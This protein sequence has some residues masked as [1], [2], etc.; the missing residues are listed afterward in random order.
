MFDIY[1]CR[2]S[3]KPNSTARPDSETEQEL[4]QVVLKEGTSMDA[5]VFILSINNPL[6]WNYAYVPSLGRYYWIISAR[7]TH[8]QLVEISCATDILATFKTYIGSSRSYVL[9]SSYTF[10]GGIIDTMFPTTAACTTATEI[11]L[12]P[13]IHTVGS[14]NISITEGCFII[15]Y[16]TK[17]IPNSDHMYGSVIYSAIEQDDLNDLVQELLDDS[18]LEDNGFELN[19]ASLAL[20]KSIVDPLSYIKS[21]IWVPVLYSAISGS[22]LS[23]LNIW[24][25]SIGVNHKI[26]RNDPPYIQYS[27]GS[28]ALTK[29]PQTL[30]KGLWTNLS[31]Y[32]RINL[33]YPP[34][35]NIEL[36]TTLTCNVNSITGYILIDLVTGMGTL[37]I[38]I[39][40]VEQGL[41][42]AQVGVPIQLSQVSKDYAGAAVSAGSGLIGLVAGAA[43]GSVAGAVA[44]GFSGITDAAQSM[45]SRH[46]S[47]GGAGSF[48]GLNGRP[49]LYQQFVTIAPGDNDHRG[50]PLCRVEQLSDLPGFIQ[51]LDGEVSVAG[52]AG[53]AEAIKEY[54]ETGFFYE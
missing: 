5:P 51:V 23:E 25:W 45:L 37:K 26:L 39:D 2:F 15:G 6:Y 3:K 29:H 49:R 53:E 16:V 46:T 35:G 21:V 8:N 32:T 38:L 17:N 52:Y 18:L 11:G 50:K 19:D 41:Y 1:L 13:W 22:A 42:H 7:V 24:D 48:S 12:S 54:L 47:T 44:S 30:E 10:A 31:P 36:D 28:L 34:F 9:R 20:Q 43:A 40:G 27:M 14:D 4:Q 33:D